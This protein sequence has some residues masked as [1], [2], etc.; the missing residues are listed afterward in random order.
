MCTHKVRKIEMVQ[1]SHNSKKYR[2][3]QKIIRQKTNRSTAHDREI[4]ITLEQH[5]PNQNQG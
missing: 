1:N 5:E 3:G 4:I 2:H